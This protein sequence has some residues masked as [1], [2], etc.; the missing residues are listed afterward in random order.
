MTPEDPAEATLPAPPKVALSLLHEETV[1]AGGFLRIRRT[2]LQAVRGEARSAAFPYDLLDRRALDASVVVAHHSGPE[3]TRVWLRSCVRPPVSLR[4]GSTAPS[5]GGNL[6]ELPAGL[7]EP[8]E[9]PRA[10]AARE[11]AEELGFHVDETALV[12]LGPPTYPAPGF[13][14]EEHHFF[15]VTID[16]DTRKEP[17]GDGSPLEQDPRIVAIPLRD[18]LAACARGAI[19]DA[20]TELALRR[21][22]DVL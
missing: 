21:L 3:G 5:L 6:W 1:G 18:A 14:G 16:P 8:E 17:E 7:V 4:P 13:I 19:P 15:H 2:Q 11:L 22:A 10:A 12:R 9:T 20:K